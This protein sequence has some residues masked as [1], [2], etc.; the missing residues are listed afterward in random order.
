MPVSITPIY[1]NTDPT[2]LFRR[3][4]LGMWTVG[5]YDPHGRWQPVS[6]YNDLDMA[7]TICHWLNGNCPGQ[8]LGCPSQHDPLN[9]TTSPWPDDGLDYATDI[10]DC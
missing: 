7:A 6:D 3:S 9:G 8:E 10:W 2:W 4:A 5:F 1:A